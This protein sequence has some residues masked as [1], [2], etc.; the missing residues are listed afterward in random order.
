MSS[1]LKIR[2]KDSVKAQEILVK[3]KPWFNGMKKFS[4]IHTRF[5][6]RPR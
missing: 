1:K 5:D 2:V 6:K 4:S 3:Y